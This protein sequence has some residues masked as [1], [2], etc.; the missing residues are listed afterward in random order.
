MSNT[1]ITM[2]MC[3]CCCIKSDSGPVL[4]SGVETSFSRPV[5]SAI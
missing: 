3:M 1:T 5:I 4:R 2:T